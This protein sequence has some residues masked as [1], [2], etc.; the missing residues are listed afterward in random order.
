MNL[1]IEES[2]FLKLLS[3]ALFP[4]KKYLEGFNSNADWRIIYEE[5]CAQAVTALV[6]ESIRLLDED[7]RPNRKLMELWEED[8][9]YTVM[10]NSVKAYAH[11]ELANIFESNEINYCIIKGAAAAV[12]YPKPDVRDMG[13]ID[14]LV[15][16]KDFERAKE[17]LSENGYIEKVVYPQIGHEVEYNKNG[18]SVELH[19]QAPGVPE[20]KLG[21][22]LYEVIQEVSKNTEVSEIGEVKFCKPCSQY[23]GLILLLHVISHIGS[24]IGIR[25]ICDWAMYVKNEL[26]Y[27]IWENYLEPILNENKILFFTKVLTKMCCKY[28]GLPIEE[29][30]WCQSVDDEICDEFMR[31]IL[32]SGNFGRKQ[33]DRNNSA[34]MLIG[35]SNQ[36]AAKGW[37]PLKVLGNLQNSGYTA[38][39][40][41]RKSKIVGCFAWI[42]IP[43]RFLKRLLTG[44]RSIKELKIIITS[45]KKRYPLINKLKIFRE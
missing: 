38:W 3:S 35:N 29:C 37:L 21:E 30:L 20:G 40:L 6:F 41:A 22:N 5:S 31:N 36:K 12:N 34:T 25:Q 19:I 42:Y 24:G 16:R 28:L 45:A 32:D 44:E 7:K 18:I 43:L 33:G 27:E 14:V 17:I 10:Q 23:N 8:S 11:K 26:N 13:D 2:F 15:C 39:P 4:D 1:S 9:I